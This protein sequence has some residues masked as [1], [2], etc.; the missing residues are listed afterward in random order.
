MNGYK[1]Q[2]KKISKKRREIQ[3]LENKHQELDLKIREAKAFLAGLETSLKHIPSEE[4]D[5]N[6]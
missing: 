4:G 1:K 5:E 2:Q 6:F 3:Q